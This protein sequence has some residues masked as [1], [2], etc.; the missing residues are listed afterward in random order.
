[1]AQSKTRELLNSMTAT[2]KKSFR[3][4][5]ESPFFNCNKAE[6]EL[7]EVLVKGLEKPEPSRVTIFGNLFPNRPYD[8]KYFRYLLSGLNKNLIHFMTIRHLEKDPLNSGALAARVLSHR[9]CEK[10]FALQHQEITSAPIHYNAN[11]YRIQFE[12]AENNLIYSANK[13]NRKVTPDYSNTLL[14]LDTFYLVKKLQLSCE[15]TNLSN[16]LNKEYQIELLDDLKKSAGAKPFCDI[17]SVMIYY[18]I[19]QMLSSR[20]ADPHFY[21]VGE[22][23]KSYASKIHPGELGEMYQYIKNYCV[24][25]VNQGELDYL[26]MLFDI[27]KSMLTNK[28][29]MNYQYMSQWEYKNIVSISLRLNEHHWCEEFINKFNSYLKPN[30]RENAL[31]YNQAYFMFMKNDFRKSIRKLQDV[32]LNDVFYQLDSRVILLKCYYEL[33][34]TDSFF[35]Q[36][37]AFRLFLLRNRH[38]SDYQRNIYR[39]L[40]KFLT[41]IVRAGYSRIKLQRISSSI[42]KEK[43]VADLN[44]LRAK[45]QEA[46]KK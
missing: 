37:S 8:D 30:E 39:N 14:H 12:A 44:W 40:I 26:R 23:L 46:I 20:E 38:I 33:D 43:N 6:R 13:Q 25:K 3:Q 24:R 15:V 35:Y 32:T 1:M 2:E 21:K 7:F 4:Y 29:L 19:L 41:A 34:D 5:L 18:H 28:T 36:A 27:Y 17:P 16:I 22:L 11:W 10:A 45:V 9:D 42:E 31:A